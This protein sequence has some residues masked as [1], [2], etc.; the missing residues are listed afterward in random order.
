V[1]ASRGSGGPLIL[2]WPRDAAWL[3]GS[4]SARLFGNGVLSVTLALYLAH[5]RLAPAA[6]GAVL[7]A[8]L[9][10][11]ALSAV[12]L[13]QMAQRRGRRRALALSAG[14]GCLA[15]LLLTTASI[16]WLL[17]LAAAIGAV[18][19]SAQD[20]GSQPALEQAAI[21]DLVPAP[22]RTDL[23]AW[24]SLAGSLAAALGAL[25]A[26]L[27]NLLGVHG[28]AGF[29]AERA[30]VALY[31]AAQLAALVAYLQLSPRADGVPT[32]LSAA[33]AR[34]PPS[35]WAWT[36]L[37][38]S[39][40]T[41]VRLGSLF[42]LDSFAGGV[43]VQGLVAYDL[44]LRFGLG[45]AAL[46]PVFFATNVAAALSYLVAARL[47]RRIGLL[48]T[49]V[50][51]HLPSNVVLMAVAWAPTWPV[52][53]ALL[54]LRSTCSQ[55]DVPTRQAYTMALVDPSERSAAASAT[56]AA[57]T[58]GAMA[59]PLVGG[60]ALA[61]PGLGLIFLLGGGL[62]I[63][64]DLALFRLFRGVPLPAEVPAPP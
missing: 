6:I 35:R 46:G 15:A 21:A 30:L 36:G 28:A 4:R 8:G 1:S 26:G 11:G 42:A 64:Y 9:L 34:R 37:H 38:R 54:V 29:G 60:A 3:I 31:G 62:K 16:A 2:G 56:G 44:H 58:L 17:G 24:Y 61:A 47:A 57:R 41:V 55:M 52:A 13:G 22:R 63:G 48:N 50:L 25:V 51:T 32:P 40:P 45:L 43:A 20:V 23:F 53:V 27:P 59:G 7:A 49:M 39:R 19:A 12:G 18:S 14:L 5:L 33:G 10:G